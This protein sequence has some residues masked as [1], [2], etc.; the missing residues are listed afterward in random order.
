MFSLFLFSIIIIIIL[1]LE[2][3]AQVDHKEND[4]G[5]GETAGWGVF[6]SSFL[7]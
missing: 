1:D 3:Y 7:Y 5:P 6:S 2:L 4:A